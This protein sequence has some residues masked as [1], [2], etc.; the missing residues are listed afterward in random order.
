MPMKMGVMCLISRRLTGL[1]IA[2]G[3]PCAAD[4]PLLHVT[5]RW[6]GGDAP[7]RFEGSDTKDL[8]LRAITRFQQLMLPLAAKSVED[9]AFYRYGRLVSRNEV[10]AD[11]TRFSI[12]VRDFHVATVA[13]AALNAPLRTETAGGCAPTAAD[14]L[15]LYQMLVGAWPL[16]LVKKNQDDVRAFTARIDQWRDRLPAPLSGSRCNC[17]RDPVVGAYRGGCKSNCPR[18][19]M[20][21]HRCGFT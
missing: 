9:T 13:R 2:R 17:R 14:E 10:G 19:S 3:K 18:R 11:P 16:D 21:R 5:G 15:M 1:W 20:E 12:S 8:R 6:L 7:D 4:R